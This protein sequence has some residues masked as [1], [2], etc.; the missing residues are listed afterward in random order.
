MFF[1]LS[2]HGHFDMA[3]YDKYF[4]GALEDYDYPEDAIRARWRACRAW[5]PDAAALRSRPDSLL[6]P[7]ERVF[8]RGS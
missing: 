3:S 2:G 8:D 6:R 7:L 4:A 1:N 5:A